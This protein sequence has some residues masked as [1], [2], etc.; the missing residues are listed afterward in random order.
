M[1][2]T[3]TEMTLCGKQVNVHTI[4]GIYINAREVPKGTPLFKLLATEV[5]SFVLECAG[6]ADYIR[7]H[8]TFQCKIG[9]Y[10]CAVAGYAKEW[11]KYMPPDC[12][13]TNPHMNK[14][15]NTAQNEI[16][17]PDVHM[18]HFG[19]PEKSMPKHI[20]EFI[21]NLPEIGEED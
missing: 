2:I 17:L 6:E 16:D 18:A 12:G 9:N 13:K 15:S 14:P 7:V 11:H 10:P 4:T 21:A 5:E 1:R 8:G 19:N 20:S 3:T